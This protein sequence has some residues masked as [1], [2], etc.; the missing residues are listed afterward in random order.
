M[1]SFFGIGLPELIL[2]MLIAGIVMGPHRIAHTA[3]WLGKVTVQLQTISRT[4]M[5]QLNSEIEAIDEGG[6]LKSAAAEIRDL[7]RQLAEL[8]KEITSVTNTAVQE[9][10]SAIDEIEQSIKPPSLSE[11][12]QPPGQNGTPPAPPIQLP[13]VIDIEGDPD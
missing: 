3:R 13:N 8:R 4:F 11:S 1:D 12:K 6:E 10:R 7:Q 2:I 9:G 5:Q